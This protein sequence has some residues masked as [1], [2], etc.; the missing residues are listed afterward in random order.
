MIKTYKYLG[1]P[2]AR[3]MGALPAGDYAFQIAEVNDV[4]ES[5]AGNLVLPVKITIQPQGVPVFANCWVGRDKDGNERDGIA[6]LLLSV[7]RTPKVGEEPDWDKLVGARGRCR[8]KVEI[9]Q[10]GALA[11]KDVNKVSFFLRPKQVG[12]TTNQS[13]SFTEAEIEKS[14]AAI[15]KVLG[16]KDPALEVEP[17]DIPF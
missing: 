9:A 2:D 15:A 4:Y 11:G 3:V 7:N 13:Q 12:P 16:V 8:L 14:Q 6:E 5:K 10:A 1:E 17:D